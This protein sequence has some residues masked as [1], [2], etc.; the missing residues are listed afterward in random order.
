LAS[1]IHVIRHW[2]IVPVILPFDG[3]NGDGCCVGNGNGIGNGSGNDT[4]DGAD[5]WAVGGAGRDAMNRVSTGPWAELK[6]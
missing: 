1:N 5:R 2:V 3:V 4:D 6:S